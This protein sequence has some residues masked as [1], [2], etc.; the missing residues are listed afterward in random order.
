MNDKPIITQKQFFILLFVC[1]ISSAIIYSSA[2]SGIA[3]AWDMLLPLII[4]IPLMI[5]MFLPSLSYGHISADGSF[6]TAKL[7]PLAYCAYFL[8]SALYSTALIY[9]FM[10]E[11]VPDDIEPKVLLALLIAGCAYASLKGIEASAR[12]SG[13]VIVFITGAVILAAVFLMQNYRQDDLPIRQGYSFLSI[14]DCVVFIISRYNCTAAYNV[15][16]GNIR[17]RSVSGGLLFVILSTVFMVSVLIMLRGSTGIYMDTSSFQIYNATEGSGDLQRLDPV[18]I[19]V[20]VCSCFCSIAMMLLASVESLRTVLKTTPHKKLCIINGVLLIFMMLFLQRE[21]LG[22]ICNK[23]LWAILNTV[24][25]F[26]L[27][28]TLLLYKKP[29]KKAYRYA[30]GTAAIFTAVITSLLLSG[31]NAP[32]LNQKLIIQGIGIDRTDRY[33]LTISVLDT[34]DTE[35]PNSSRLIYSEGESIEEAINN[36]EIKRGKKALFS[37]CIFMITDKSSMENFRETFGYFAGRKDISTGVKVIECGITGSDSTAE[38]AVKTA[39]KEYGDINN[40][41]SAMY[42][43]QF[44]MYDV[45]CR[46]L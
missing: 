33:K 6:F 18:F 2:L 29:A 46:L 42:N 30:V 36:L 11:A 27:P 43:V 16:S 31:C 5:I 17:K 40:V 45:K 20:T 38:S 32:Q 14:S 19:L 34:G 7:I 22:Y 3:S 15:F 37:Q 4:T 28:L 21:F 44:T 39:F 10:L 41:Q 13:I 1:R 23:Y 12:M 25:I 24:F 35:K 26:I 8:F 9:G